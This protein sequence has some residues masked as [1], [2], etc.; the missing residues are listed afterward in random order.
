MNFRQMKAV[1]AELYETF[2]NVAE[3]VNEKNPEY[4]VCVDASVKYG[5]D[6]EDSFCNVG[7]M[8]YPIDSYDVTIFSFHRYVHCYSFENKVEQAKKRLCEKLEENGIK[9]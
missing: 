2:N 6:D 8:I 9:Y 7:F 4:K 1:T 5:K 3:R